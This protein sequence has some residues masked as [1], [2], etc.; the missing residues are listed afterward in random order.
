MGC[1]DMEIWNTMSFK[2]GK[3]DLLLLLLRGFLV[4]LYLLPLLEVQCPDAESKGKG[5]E[6][7]KAH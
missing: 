7:R 2:H 4:S 6:D 5:E 3:V 1:G